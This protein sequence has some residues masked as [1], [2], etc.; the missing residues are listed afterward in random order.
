MKETFFGIKGN[1][2]G[3]DGIFVYKTDE[4]WND[5]AIASFE[6]I[7]LKKITKNY[8]IFYFPMLNQYL[9]FD[10]KYFS[11]DFKETKIYKFNKI[12]YKIIKEHNDEYSKKQNV[13]LPQIRF[14]I[15]GIDVINN[16]NKN[17]IYY[18]IS[19]EKIS[20]NIEYLYEGRFLIGLCGCGYEGCD[21]II[22]SIGNY[23]NEIYW[24]VHSE[25][26]GGPN[27]NNHKYFAFNKHDYELLVEDIKNE[28]LK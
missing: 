2:Y 3:Y 26:G 11:E 1:N 9:K 12:N 21:D 7:K 24:D 27:N 17:C 18:G 23:N 20:E 25:T 4:N 16:L 14:I 8:A 5:I 13:F 6:E 15:D 10:G 19:K 22:A 28:L